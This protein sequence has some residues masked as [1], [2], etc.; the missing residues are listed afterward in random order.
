MCYISHIKCLVAI[1]MLSCVVTT[2]SF[3]KSYI[4]YSRPIIVAK[5][6]DDSCY[7]AQYYAHYNF[8]TNEFI[9]G[10]DI[11]ETMPKP[12][13]SD[14]HTLI[15]SVMFQL[16][17]RESTANYISIELFVDK[18]GVLRGCMVIKP[19]DVL[20]AQNIIE[21]LSKNRFTPATLYGMNID[22]S[23][24]LPIKIENGCKIQKK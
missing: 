14:W 18:Q 5:T 4:E 12:I 2:I 22:Y 16:N 7:I 6:T 24:P 3:N 17:I 1:S 20:V 19:E 13:N 11:P 23:I 21:I 15:D 10:T 9:Y 8:E